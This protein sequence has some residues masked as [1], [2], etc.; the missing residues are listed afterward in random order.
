M[1]APVRR[2]YP[3]TELKLA[4]IFQEQDRLLFTS[5]RAGARHWASHSHLLSF[6]RMN[7]IIGSALSLASTEPL[8]LC[9]MN[10]QKSWMPFQMDVV[11]QPR[12]RMC[13]FGECCRIP[14][15]PAAPVR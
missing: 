11:V 6:P 15:C 4:R 12:L 10:S 14:L 3:S 8:S 1:E 13:T 2:G 9:L 7:R 5:S